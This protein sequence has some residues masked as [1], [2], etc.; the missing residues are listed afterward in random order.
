[1]VQ[2]GLFVCTGRGRCRHRRLLMML[3]LLVVV[4]VV[5]QGVLVRTCCGRRHLHLLLLLVVVVVL[6]RVVQ[7]G[8]VGR[9]GCRRGQRLLL[10]VLVQ[11]LLGVQLVR[12]VQQHGLVVVLVARRCRRRHGQGLSIRTPLLH[13]LRGG[14]GV[15][16]RGV[17]GGWQG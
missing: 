11:G 5:Q 9:R 3:P 6:E 7:R 10:V 16:M 17:V 12:V 15:H 14:S 13:H 2:Q 1:M 8:L 4:R